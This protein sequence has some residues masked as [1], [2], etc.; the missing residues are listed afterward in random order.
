[1][2]RLFGK[3]QL[4]SAQGEPAGRGDAWRPRL[5]PRSLEYPDSKAEY[6][7]VTREWLVGGGGTSENDLTIVELLSA[8][9]RHAKTYYL[10]AEGNPTSELATFGTLVTRLRSTYG[11]TAAIEFGP[12]R[13]TAFRQSLV[14]HGLSRRV[15][16]RSISRVRQIFKWGAENDLIPGSVLESL[17]CVSGLRFGKTTAKEL[18]LVRPVAAEYVE[19]TLPFLSPQVRAMLELQ[20]LTG[21]RSGEL[22]CIRGS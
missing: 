5:L 13:L 15:I 16:N 21:M 22:C 1:M 19:A 4:P 11:R 12:L 7:R 14:D 20:Q 8:V 18:A 6:A 2:P 10:D 9:L 3:S 17:R